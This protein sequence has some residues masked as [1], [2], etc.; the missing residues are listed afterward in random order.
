M[1][2]LSNHRALMDCFT[3]K[4]VLKKSGYPELEF[5]GDKRI[6]PTCVISAI[7]AKKLLCK[8]CEAYLAHMVDKSTPKITLDG[9]PVV[10]EFSDVFLE[11]LP[12]LP[13]DI[14][15]EFEMELLS[16]S[17][18]V[19]KPLYRMALVELKELK[20]QLQDLVDNG[21]IRLSVS[22]WGTPVLFVKKKDGT[23]RLYIDYRKLNKITIKTSTPY[24]RLMIYLINCKRQ[25]CFLK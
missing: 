14:E 9:M 13:P 23:M 5:E 19:S 11:N 10:R 12:G 25:V 17:A 22:P 24:R 3:K 2:W 4:I 7:E 20:T 21:F 15:L 8:G 6:L 1:D 18:P 16:S